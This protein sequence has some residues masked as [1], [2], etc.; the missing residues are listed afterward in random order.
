MHGKRCD[1]VTN[2]TAKKLVGTQ[3]ISDWLAMA[4][5]PGTDDDSVND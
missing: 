5:S 2:R 1:V 4:V 3:V